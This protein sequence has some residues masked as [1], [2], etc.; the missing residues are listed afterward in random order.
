VI[1]LGVVSQMVVK[2]S[3]SESDVVALQVGQT[4]T[5]TLPGTGDKTYPAKVTQVAELGT[6]SNRLVTYEVLITFDEVPAGLLVGQSA[7]VT[8]PA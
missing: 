2:A 7:N 3:F 1:T 4:A 5:I 6:V 8:V